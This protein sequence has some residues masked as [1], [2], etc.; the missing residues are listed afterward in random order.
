MKIWLLKKTGAFLLFAWAAAS[1]IFLLVHTIPGD[2]VTAMLG[3]MP[4]PEDIRR[5]QQ[6]MR[7]DRPLAEQYAHFMQKLLRLDLGESIIDRR[8]VLASIRR[9][10]PNTIILAAAA[11]LL[12]LLIA[13][14]LGMLAALKGRGVCYTAS[15]IFST[16]GLAVP[17]FLSGIL[18]IILF[19]LRW[20]W[21]P[22][23]GSGEIRFLIL[24]ALTLAISLG[25]F[26]VRVIHAAV[27]GE[28]NQPYVLLA[29]AK[30][31]SGFHIFS[32]HILRNALIPIITIIGLQFGALLSGAIVIENVFSWPGI[33]TLLITAIRQRDFP[34][35]QGIALFLAC[36]Y[37]LLNLLVDL[38]YPIIDPRLRHD[39]R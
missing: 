27:A 37:L 3:K 18:L 22:V 17:G 9:Y 39:R 11:M 7:L 38:T 12:A 26:L 30:G 36:L 19:S 1:L 23:S 8:P 25:A 15:M 21:L 13:M 20:H 24:P 35:I 34:M 4:R 32:R 6:A 14:P 31:L 28:M 2:P 5:L 29:R 10:F 33:G 16:I